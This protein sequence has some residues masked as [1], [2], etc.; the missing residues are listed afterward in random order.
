MNNLENYQDYKILLS[1]NT[2]QDMILLSSSFLHE[3]GV[4]TCHLD[5]RI[6]CQ[7]VFQMSHEEL[8]KARS[9][10]S[11][12]SQAKIE[13]Y[14][15]LIARRC[16]HEPIA[17]LCNEK[18]FMGLDFYV[19][20][21]VLIPRPDSET[22]ISA[23]FQRFKDTENDLSILDI[24]TGSGCLLLSLL[25]TYINATGLGIDVSQD[26]VDVA[27]TNSLKLGL[28]NRSCFVVESA[29]DIGGIDPFSHDIVISNPPYLSNSD[30]NKIDRGV[31]DYEP[32]LA[33]YGGND[34]MALYKVIGKKSR[35]LLKDHGVLVIECGI[36]QDVAIRSILIDNGFSRVEI[37]YDLAGIARCIVASK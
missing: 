23:I 8:I 11:M 1:C 16:Q 31:K 30:M 3:A 7:H 4:D 37:E 17:Y 18:E 25:H 19:D 32:N 20:S 22:L 36:G 12:M 26:A 21:R 14:I 6:L 9:D 5:A 34:G 15:L 2:I 10:T 27:N 24:G 33:L 29:W 35:T 13:R 28:E